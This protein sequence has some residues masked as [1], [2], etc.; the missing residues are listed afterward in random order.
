VARKSDIVLTC[1]PTVKSVEDVYLGKNGI[2]QGAKKGQ[3]IADH[4]TVNRRTSLK[5]AKEAQARGIFFLDA[6]ISGGPEGAQKAT[7][8]IMVGGDK[9]AFEKVYPAFEAMGRLVRYMGP[10]GAGTVTK[11]VN[12]LLTSV[13]IASASEALVLGTKAGVNPKEL[14]DVLMVSYGYS[15]Q[16]ERL[17]PM[18]LS[19]KFIAGGPNHIINKDIT[20]ALELA[21]DVGAPAPLLRATSKISDKT[22][23]MGLKDWDMASMIVVLEKEAGVEVKE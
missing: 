20:C 2:F 10:S 23:E 15:K 4:S 7:L 14:L 8:S 1:L 22:L 21:E 3:I 13:H 19:R 18:A 12:Q 17:A 9:A 6:P 16:L 5:M 11:L